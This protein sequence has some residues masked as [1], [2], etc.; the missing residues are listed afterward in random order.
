MKKCLPY[1]HLQFNTTSHLEQIIITFIY[2][3]S[4]I[5]IPTDAYLPTGLLIIP[6]NSA[7][8]PFLYSDLPDV[9]SAQKRRFMS[10]IVEVFR[11]LRSGGE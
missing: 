9:M 4:G 3:I 7:L 10:W 8:N 2:I 1:L 11:R 6:I 5:E